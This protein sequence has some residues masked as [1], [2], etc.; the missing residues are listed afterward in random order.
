MKPLG[1]RGERKRTGVGGVDRASRQVDDVV[2]ADDDLAGDLLGAGSE[3]ERGNGPHVVAE[4]AP[5]AGF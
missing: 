2:H 1:W 5:E 3:G 4:D